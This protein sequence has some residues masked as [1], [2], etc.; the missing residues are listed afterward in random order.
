MI[1]RNISEGSSQNIYIPD[2]NTSLPEASNVKAKVAIW[3]NK[4]AVERQKSIAPREAFK[5]AQ[6]ILHAIEPTEPTM[7]ES[8]TPS[9]STTAYTVEDVENPNI[10]SATIIVVENEDEPSIEKS[11]SSEKLS[12]AETS[13]AEPRIPVR[14]RLQ[15]LA[16]KV[17]NTLTV[18]SFRDS[19]DYLENVANHFTLNGLTSDRSI[20]ALERVVIKTMDRGEL[21]NEALQHLNEAR[22]YAHRQKTDDA[23]TEIKTVLENYLPKDLE[24]SPKNKTEPKNWIEG[25]KFQKRAERHGQVETLPGKLLRGIQGEVQKQQ[26]ENILNKLENVEKNHRNGEFA[27]YLS[28]EAM[29]VYGEIIE[30]SNL[31]GARPLYEQLKN[32]SNIS[33]REYDLPTMLDNITNAPNINAEIRQKLQAIILQARGY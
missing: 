32:E 25:R 8:L 16:S 14:L 19:H 28:D 27:Y 1:N 5:V 23:V 29:A 7:P 12:Q 30:T 18:R 22:R 11:K 20:H 6:L 24:S 13:T 31:R 26:A 17:R 15:N 3:D 4:I 9:S 21:R 2:N 10:H 33:I